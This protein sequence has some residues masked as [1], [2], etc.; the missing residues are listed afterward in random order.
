MNLEKLTPAPWFA[1][2]SQVLS[3]S[4][5]KWDA[6]ICEHAK[7]DG[8]DAA[9]IALARNAFDVMMRRG[10][11]VTKS[12]L[13][14]WYVNADLETCVKFAKFLGPP[15]TEPSPDPFT[16]LVAADEWYAANVE[17]K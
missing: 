8:A 16:A 10:W 7:A 6:I 1:H 12:P 5:L 2:G 13:G 3:G 9:F 15:H 17:G 4:P 14:G 11:G